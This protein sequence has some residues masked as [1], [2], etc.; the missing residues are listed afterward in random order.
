MVGRNGSVCNHSNGVAPTVCDPRH[1]IVNVNA[2]CGGP[3]DYF[4]C[5]PWRAPGTA[6]VFDSCGVASGHRG[7]RP[8]LHGETLGGQY[9]NTSH[10]K[11]GDAG[12]EVPPAMRFGTV[13]QAGS[14]VTVSWAITANHGSGYQYNLARPS[15]PLTEQAFQRTPFASSG[16]RASAGTGARG[17]AEA[18]YPSTGYTPPR[19]PRAGRPGCAAPPN[20]LPVTCS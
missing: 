12:S 20:A 9:R 16:S 15:W 7:L 18:S 19:A 2:T 5:S 1:F 13:W 3:D 6:P 14:T 8:L 17:M 4:C 10:T 11:L